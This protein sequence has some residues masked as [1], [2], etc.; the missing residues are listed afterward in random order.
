[1]IVQG[2]LGTIATGLVE[3]TIL[4]DG[5][6]WP[7]ARATC[8]FS[9][10]CSSLV[11]TPQA[12]QTVTPGVHTIG[13]RVVRQTGT[14]RFAYF[15]TGSVVISRGGAPLQTIPLVERNGTIGVGEAIVYQITVSG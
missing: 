2:G 13:F 1:M 10:G 9:S 8:Q 5:E 11:L 12:L 3:A 14:G 4:L 15:S 6:E 7:G